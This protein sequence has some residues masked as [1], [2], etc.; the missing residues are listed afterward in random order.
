ME[1]YIRIFCN[2]CL[3]CQSTIGRNRIPRPLS[4]ALHATKANELIHFDFLYL[5]PETCGMKYVL[6]VKDDLS[7]FCKLFPTTDLAGSTAASCLLDWFLVY[8]IVQIWVSD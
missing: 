3:H 5:G 8:G 1:S 6:I 4:H 7:S 2:T